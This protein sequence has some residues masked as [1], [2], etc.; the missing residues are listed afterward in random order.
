MSDGLC[1]VSFTKK[2]PRGLS[3]EKQTFLLAERAAL[4]NAL[5]AAGL[6]ADPGGF[7][8]GAPRAVPQMADTLH[9][10][11]AITKRPGTR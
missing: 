7:C 8:S 1:S 4:I 2:A 6:Q 5:S 10:S 9:C 11:A 3:D